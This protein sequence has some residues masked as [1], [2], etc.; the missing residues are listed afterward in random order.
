MATLIVQQAGVRRAGILNGRVVI[1]RRENSHI[2]IPDRYVS[3]IHAWIGQADGRYFIAD[4]GSRSGTRVNGKLIDGRHRLSDGDKIGIG[5]ATITFRAN[6]SLPPDAQEIDLSD[7]PTAS[8]DGIF[9]DCSCGAPLWAPWDFAGRV[10]QCRY[11]GQMLEMP[12]AKTPVIRR[13]VCSDTMVPGMPSP[14]IRKPRP[15][16][17]ARPSLFDAPE[18]SKA[19]KQVPEK[20]PAETLCGACQTPISLL[21]ETKTCPDCGVAFHANCWTENR[22]CS[23]Y[24]CRQVGILDADAPHS[25]DAPVPV[26]SAIDDIPEKP[27]LQWEHILLP[28][29]LI[30]SVIGMIAFGIP[31]LLTGAAVMAFRMRG[32]SAGRTRL[33][34][35]ALAVCALAAA[36]GFVFSWYWWISAPAVTRAKL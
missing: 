1:G 4:T 14:V 32:G 29:A 15:P 27:S 12:A 30:G 22:G 23:S 18:T 11:C 19:K 20:T 16:R 34:S 25:A 7:H 21:D 13:D 6:G 2:V 35:G 9:M 5:P 31:A 3:R 33:V 26:Q 10:G 24:G 36:A 8:D 17:M 28:L